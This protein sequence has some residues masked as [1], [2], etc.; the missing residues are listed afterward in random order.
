M[1]KRRCTVSSQ[2]INYKKV[3]KN[4]LS[5][6]GTIVIEGRPYIKSKVNIKVVIQY[7]YSPGWKIYRVFHFRQAYMSSGIVA[8]DLSI[9]S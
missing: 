3:F 4:Y 9:K 5:L 6:E 8:S 2:R 1:V 7:V